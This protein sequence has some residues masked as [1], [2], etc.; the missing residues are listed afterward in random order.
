MPFATGLILLGEYEF[1]FS[2]TRIGFP[3][4]SAC[5]AIL[6]QTTTGLFGFHQATGYG[7]MK[8]DR[9][10]KKFAN[11]VNGH[12]AGVGTGLNLYVGAKLGAGGT[13]S[14]GMPGMQ[15]FVAEIGA[16]AGELRFD[17][18]ARC[19]DLSYGRPGAQGVFVEFGV[20]GGACDMMVND[21]IE[22]HG[23]GNKGAPLGNAGDHVI[24]HAGKSDFSI[25][26][27]V[28]LRADT[29]NQK[30]VDPIPVALR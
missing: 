24:S 21:W 5:R 19:Y 2:T 3:S 20:N 6:Y 29:T 17:G 8:I 9:D 26:A 25:P 23:D 22:H 12:S 14:M 28:F 16:I 15:E 1:G 30:R 13:Y 11:F 10:A 18:P 4:I 27:S 7:P